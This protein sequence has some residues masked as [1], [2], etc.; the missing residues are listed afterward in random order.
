M[1]GDSYLVGGHLYVWSVTKNN[2]EDVGNIQG[3]AGT[4]GEK[5][6][7]GEIGAQGPQG[8]VGPQGP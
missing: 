1:A 2:W 4:A 3:P 7:K 8:E 5:G 6:E